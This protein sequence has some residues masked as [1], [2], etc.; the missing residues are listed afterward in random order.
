[1]AEPRVLLVTKGLDLGGLERIVADL[2]VGLAKRGVPVEVAVV[3]SDRDRLA[4]PIESSGVTLHRLGGT[5]RIGRA[6]A[7]RL[8]RLVRGGQYDIVHVHGPLPAALVRVVAPRGGSAVAVVTTSHTPWGSLN[9]LTRLAWRLTA[10][11]DT[12]SIAVSSAV[13]ASLPGRAGRNCLVVPHGVDLQLVARARSAAPA[14]S[15]VCTV[16]TV[17]SHRDAKNYPNLL[18]AVR[19]A[20][21]LGARL[22]LVS[23]G[24]GPGLATHA[25]L[26][27][28]LGLDDVVTFEP[29]TEDILARI[30]DSDVLVVASDYE[31]QPIVVAEALA[32][33]KPVVATAVGRVPEMVTP[34]VGRIVPPGDAEA[35]GAALAELANSPETRLALARAAAEQPVSWTLDDA[36]DAHQALYKRLADSSRVR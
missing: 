4:G 22:R 1:M 10:G 25:A 21:D 14:S 6:A 24:E 30:A 20:I 23:I 32:L 13:A 17:A 36:L 26:A 2:A 29:P 16:L 3:N 11:R 19:I 9:R 31:G 33:H 34:S 28:Q 27:H 15:D 18:K 12:A 5:D 35:L 7:V 8:A